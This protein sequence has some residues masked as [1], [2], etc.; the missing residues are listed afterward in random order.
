MPQTLHLMQ[1]FCNQAPD[2]YYS[3]SYPFGIQLVHVCCTY[4]M[5]VPVVVLL[6]NAAANLYCLTIEQECYS[7]CA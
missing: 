5:L 3:S 1:P 2:Q 7:K 4:S 6:G